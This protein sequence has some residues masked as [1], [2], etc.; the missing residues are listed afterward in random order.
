MEGWKTAAAYRRASADA[1]ASH[2]APLYRMLREV[3]CRFLPPQGLCG[4]H[5]RL[6]GA[7]W[8][9]ALAAHARGLAARGRFS[10]RLPRRSSFT[11]CCWRRCLAILPAR[12]QD[13][14]FAS[15]HRLLNI[16]CW[17]A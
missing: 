2:A 1:F 5:A 15:L 3:V 9:G 11:I 7:C 12:S 14:A 17:L 4:G 16:N 13:G 6:A 10:T 8:K